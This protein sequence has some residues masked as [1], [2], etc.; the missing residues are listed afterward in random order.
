MSYVVFYIKV[1]VEGKIHKLCTSQR[2]LSPCLAGTEWLLHF[3][4]ASCT[5]YTLS[6]NSAGSYW[7]SWIVRKYY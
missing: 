1:I 4:Y 2:N 3:Q 5:I 6:G 7:D